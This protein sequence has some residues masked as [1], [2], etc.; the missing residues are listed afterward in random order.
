MNEELLFYTYGQDRIT[1]QTPYQNITIVTG[2]PPMSEDDDNN[3]NNITLNTNL[4]IESP[5][6]GDFIT[7]NSF[8]SY[9]K[10]QVIP[11][12]ESITQ[13]TETRTYSVTYG[14]SQ[15]ESHSDGSQLT[16]EQNLSLTAN[17]NYWIFYG[18]PN[19]TTNIQMALF[20]T[21]TDINIDDLDFIN[22][23]NGEYFIYSCNYVEE[24]DYIRLYPGEYSA[25]PTYY[26]NA[27]KDWIQNVSNASSVTIYTIVDSKF[28]LLPTLP[29]VSTDLVL[30]PNTIPITNGNVSNLQTDDKR[31]L[32]IMRLASRT[33]FS[34]VPAEQTVLYFYYFTDSANKG[35]TQRI[36]Y[37]QGLILEQNTVYLILH[38]DYTTTTFQIAYFIPEKEDFNIDSINFDLTDNGSYYIYK[39]P[40]GY[41][42]YYLTPTVSGTTAPPYY[43]TINNSQIQTITDESSVVVYKA[44]DIGLK[45]LPQTA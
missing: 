45:L 22:V 13:N 26:L 30:V 5:S 10:F 11:G 2:M 8:G 12:S 35:Y 15:S 28:N 29:A 34:G 19:L 24:N 38:G 25:T 6:T 39:C 4:P 20:K 21:D 23:E 9:T 7:S 18:N 43:F 1:F 31:H 27:N 16:Y 40:L 37:E 3:E 36:A 32:P 33:D 41:S 14:N 17:K 44:N 42:A